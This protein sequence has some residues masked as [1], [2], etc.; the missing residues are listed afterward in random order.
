MDNQ[1]APAPVPTPDV[2]PPAPTT[3]PPMPPVSPPT[4]PAPAT[5]N[6]APEVLASSEHGSSNKVIIA[7]S[8]VVLVVILAIFGYFM[9]TRTIGNTSAPQASPEG[10]VNAPSS[11]QAALP[12]PTASPEPTLEQQ[13]TGLNNSTDSLDK[14]LSDIDKGLND[15]QGDLS[16]Q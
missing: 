6:V 1:A 13:L 5:A 3:A 9:Y 4:P 14:D 15:K 7:I 12:V 11:P 2:T 16:S 10:N 8:V